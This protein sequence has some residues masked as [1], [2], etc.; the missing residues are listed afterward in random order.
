[1]FLAYFLFLRFRNTTG[2]NRCLPEHYGELVESKALEAPRSRY[3]APR[4]MA[5][6]ETA[7]LGESPP[8]CGNH[9]H[10]P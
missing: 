4:K 10:W 7:P 1:M 9:L 2:S 8:Q 3:R 6:F 5:V